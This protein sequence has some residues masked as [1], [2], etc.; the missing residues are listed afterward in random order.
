MTGYHRILEDA[1]E[2]FGSI[3]PG[4]TPSVSLPLLEQ[5]CDRFK[6]KRPFADVDVLFIQH[7]IGPFPA[8]IRAMI[9]CG[10]DPD[11]AWFID[12]PYSTHNAVVDRL[13]ELGCPA[14]QMT[15]RFTDPLEPYNEA[16]FQRVSSLMEL[17]EQRKN[18]RP[19]L[20]VDDGAYFLR[21]LNS[22]R[23]KHSSRLSAYIGTSVVEQTTRGYRYLFNNALEVIQACDISVVSIARCKTKKIFEGP[24]IG[25]AHSRAMR[26]FMG[27]QGITEARRAAIIGCGVIGEATTAELCRM[28]P[29]ISVDVVDIDASVRSRVSQSFD[30]A[31]GVPQL[32][33]DHEYD[34]VIGCTGYSSFH[35]DQRQLLADGAVLASGSS[36][37]VEFNRAGFI[38]L[39]DRY[40]D[41]EIEILDRKG[42]TAK[43][44][45]AEITFRHE[46]SRRFTFL[47]A[48]FPVNFDGS[49]ESLPSNIIQATHGLLF[50]ASIQG[51]TEKGSG[52]VTINSTE[53]NWIFDEALLQLANHQR[54]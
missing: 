10:L 6:A 39:A 4:E 31:N 52:V 38:E 43:G 48:G 8:H 29:D 22:L 54:S 17:L 27:A 34:I 12:I 50:S 49:L 15:D 13:L 28:Y 30:Q 3:P 46:G 9:E 1:L 40:A 26:K 2:N 25:A 47:N 18:P 16:Q 7:H 45:H 36:A 37:A 53:D 33:N 19:L 21:Y 14:H 41:D 35:L 20:V 42:T 32:N 24:F 5:L 11:R 44:I 51:L 23:E